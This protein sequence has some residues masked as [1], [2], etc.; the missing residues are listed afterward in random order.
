MPQSMLVGV[1]V[2]KVITVVKVSYEIIKCFVR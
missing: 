2:C 1:G